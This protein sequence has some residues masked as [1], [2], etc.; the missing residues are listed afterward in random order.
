MSILP[1]ATSDMSNDLESG[2]YFIQCSFNHAHPHALFIHW[3]LS[4]ELSLPLVS[5]DLRPRVGVY[6]SEKLAVRDYTPS[7]LLS[8]KFLERVDLFSQG[9]LGFQS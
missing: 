3:L 4:N 6:S 8:L 9:Y 2:V 1:A 7:R 5:L